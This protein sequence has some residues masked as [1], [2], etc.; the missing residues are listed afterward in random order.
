M[1][2]P[3]WVFRVRAFSLSPLQGC[4]CRLVRCRQVLASGNG[5]IPRARG[6]PS[7][8]KYREREAAARTSPGYIY[9]RSVDK[10]GFSLNAR[11]LAKGMNR[12]DA[13]NGFLFFL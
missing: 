4:L 3:K 10:G 12:R 5:Q 2:L 7:H 13:R 8:G 1:V 6:E 11:S 9:Q